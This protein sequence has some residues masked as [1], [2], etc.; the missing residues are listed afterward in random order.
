MKF[1]FALFLTFFASFGLQAQMLNELF[2]EEDFNSDLP[3]A[4]NEKPEA[5]VDAEPVPVAVQA[6][7]QKQEAPRSSYKLP[8]PPKKETQIFASKPSLPE[9]GRAKQ[10]NMPALG[11]SVSKK[12]RGEELSLF[13]MRMKKLGKKT[14]SVVDKF[15]VSGVHLKMTPDEVIDI[16]TKN[17]YDLKT[18]NRHIPELNAWK[19]KRKCLDSRR[20]S[21]KNLKECISQLA[22]DSK[23]EY[24]QAVTFENK[25]NR[26]KLTVEF[27]S[28]YGGNQAFRIY[29]SSKG[30]HSLGVTEEGV[31]LKAKRRADFLRTLIS[32]YGRPDD[33]T[34]LIWGGA[35]FGAKLTAEISD[36]FLDATV[37]LEDITLED[38]ALDKMADEDF[39]KKSIGTFSF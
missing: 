22:K 36:T 11:A 30:D 17:G 24:I 21:Y 23:S 32:K 9:L 14:D 12:S 16:A 39:R 25:K 38:D 33:E 5:N 20:Q 4:T 2:E 29:Y 8:K 3:E 28:F 35:G 37:I 26:E 27:T 19:Y 10:K 1:I 18:V 15:D 7:K 6:V 34:S 31:Y 13:E